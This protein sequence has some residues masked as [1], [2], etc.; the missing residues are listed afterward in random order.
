MMKDVDRLDRLIGIAVLGMVFIAA[1]IIGVRWWAEKHAER[2]AGVPVE[3]SEKKQ[4]G[5]GPQVPLIDYGR[6]GKNQQLDT[7]MQARKE[8]LGIEKG[9]DMVAKPEESL[10]IGSYIVPMKE[11]LDQIR[12]KEGKIIEKDLAAPAGAEKARGAGQAPGA[13]T[14]QKARKEN[15]YG[16]YVVRPGDNIWN[17][18]FTLL[19]SYFD[20]RGIR[21]SS[22]SDEPGDQGR[23]SGVGKL[24]KFSEKMV[25]IYNIRQGKIDVDLGLIHPLNKIV[26]FRMKQIFNLLDQIDYR[27][28]DRLQFDGDTL[29]LP[30]RK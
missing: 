22:V 26:I 12:L 14:G 18:H 23:S 10:K 25:Y 5:A 7:L 6:L 27:Q 19:K 3:K 29:W 8:S 2:M 15:F 28:V 13:D 21:L 30:A 9:L 24:L 16:I 1:L 17:I 11:V 20:R 4:A